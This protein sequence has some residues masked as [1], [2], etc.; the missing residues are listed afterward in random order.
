MR[1]R[2]M[3]LAALLL[4][5]V[6]DKASAFGMTVD[7]HALSMPTFSVQPATGPLNTADVQVLDL[8]AGTYVFFGRDVTNVGFVFSVDSGGIVQY[9]PPFEGFLAGAG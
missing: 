1:F 7:A 3:L 5:S 6:V 2:F 8:E 4:G 9:D